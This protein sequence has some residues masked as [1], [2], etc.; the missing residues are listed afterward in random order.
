MRRFYCY[1]VHSIASSLMGELEAVWKEWKE[2]LRQRSLWFEGAVLNAFQQQD[3]A[4]K[5]KELSKAFLGLKD[6]Q[7][8]DEVQECRRAVERETASSLQNELE[9]VKCKLEGNVTRVAMENARQVETIHCVCVCVC[10]CVWSIT[11]SHT[12]NRSAFHVPP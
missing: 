6:C 12:M 1:T 3:G 5:R 7:V 11:L 9:M 8:K 4:E 10:A 2:I